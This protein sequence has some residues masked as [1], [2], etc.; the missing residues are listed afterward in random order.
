MGKYLG[1]YSSHPFLLASRLRLEGLQ[2]K[3]PNTLNPESFEAEQSLYPN[4]V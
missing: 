2:P 4:F 1:L 3:T